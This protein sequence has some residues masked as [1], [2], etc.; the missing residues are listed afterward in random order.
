MILRKIEYIKKNQL[1]GIED[2]SGMFALACANMILRGDG[3]ANL[4]KGD[5]F[6]LSK[7]IKKKY[8]CDV[9]FLNP[10]YSQKDKDSKELHYV[11]NCLSS[12]KKGGTCIAIVPLKSCYC[13]II[14]TKENIIKKSYT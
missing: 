3:K 1:I 8:D 6:D 12:L 13:N 7:T 5:C 9:G 10:P 4:Y 2:L 14:R 11:M